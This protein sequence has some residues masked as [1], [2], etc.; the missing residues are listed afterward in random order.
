M[1]LF[2]KKPT[3]EKTSLARVLVGFVFM[4]V[5]IKANDLLETHESEIKQLKS[6]GFVDDSTAAIEYCK[7]EL[8][9]EVKTILRGEV[10]PE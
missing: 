9:A 10:L 1:N 2:K 7:T 6:D 5:D 8:K 4:G 3:D